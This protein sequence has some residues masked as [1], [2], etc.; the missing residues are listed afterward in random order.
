[1]LALDCNVAEALSKVV[2]AAIA[3]AVS[4]ITADWQHHVAVLAVVS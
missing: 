1:M 2:L 4:L 3:S